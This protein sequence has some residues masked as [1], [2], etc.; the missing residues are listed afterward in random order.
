MNK[1][2]YFYLGY[3]QK[4]HSA[5]GRLKVKLEVDEPGDYRGLDAV[6]VK[7]GVDYVPFL[8]KELSM[9]Q[10]GLAVMELDDVD[11]AEQAEVLVGRQLYLPA[12]ALPTLSE[13]QFYYHEIKG[14]DVVDKNEGKLGRVEDVL[15][16][17][18]QDLLQ[19]FYNQNEVLI[20]ISDETIEKVDRD[21]Q[22][23]HII[24]PDGLLDVYIN[25]EE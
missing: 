10:K 25:K 22:T 18:G 4:L 3:V 19:V 12:D 24:M 13:Q 8:V 15:E 20:P 1:Q 16:Y 2:E 17:P 14:F 21:T 6:F 7:I 11:D 23:L 5:D 9:M